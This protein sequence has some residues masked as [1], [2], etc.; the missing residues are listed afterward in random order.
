MN[1]VGGV[2]VIDKVMAVIE[3]VRAALTADP[4]ADLAALAARIGTT[5]KSARATA[6]VLRM[7]GEV[8]R[9]EKKSST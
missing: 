5:T 1:S 8:A 7:R 4:G 3:A 2:G 6:S 9:P